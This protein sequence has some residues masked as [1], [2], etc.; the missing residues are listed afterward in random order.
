MTA[1]NATINGRRLEW[2]APA[3]WPDGTSFLPFF[4]HACMLIQ[5]DL[6]TLAL[7]NSGMKS[8]YPTEVL[9]D[10]QSAVEGV[11]KGIHDP[12]VQRQAAERMDRMREQLRLRHGV[13]EVAVGIVRESRDE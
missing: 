8:A 11:M 6:L 4:L 12:E 10:L 1:I 2:D 9:A 3:N 5:I 7:D 13:T